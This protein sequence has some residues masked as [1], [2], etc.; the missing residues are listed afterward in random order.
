MTAIAARATRRAAWFMFG[1]SGGLE[2]RGRRAQVPSSQ[3]RRRA[4]SAG[5]AARAAAEACAKTA[6]RAAIAKGPRTRSRP[7]LTLGLSGLHRTGPCRHPSDRAR[8]LRPSFSF[9][10]ACALRHFSPSLPLLAAKTNSKFA[11]RRHHQEACAL[12]GGLTSPASESAGP[13]HAI[14]PLRATQSGGTGTVVGEATPLS[15]RSLVS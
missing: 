6:A 2:R 9:Q 14:S 5:R 11:T 4:L 15:A 13:G 3:I 12:F 10:Q 1:G 7:N 8:Q